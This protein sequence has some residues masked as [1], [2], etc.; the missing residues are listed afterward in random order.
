[1]YLVSFYSNTVPDRQHVRKQE[2][3]SF[4][5]YLDKFQTTTLP[6]KFDRKTVF[7]LSSLVYDTI[8]QSYKKSIYPEIRNE[9]F[10]FVP[11]DLQKKFPDNIFRC[12]FLLPKSENFIPVI[13]AL[14]HFQDNLQY[15][16]DLFLVLYTS[17]GDYID[18]MKIAGYNIDISEKFSEIGISYI[19]VTREY[20][21]KDPPINKHQDLFYL[22]ENQN[23]YQIGNNGIIIP[24]QQNLKIG[25]F[26]G[27]WEGYFFVEK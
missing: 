4:V 3:N 15:S 10:C 23:E 24:K 1:M 12:L 11:I 5:E 27:N 9:F 13:L 18:F 6:L 20:Q 19:V 25:Y 8:N 16:L 26:K 22:V 21:F 14:D 2:V 7:G 17:K